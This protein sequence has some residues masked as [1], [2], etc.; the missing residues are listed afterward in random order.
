MRSA[1]SAIKRTMQIKGVLSTRSSVMENLWI[2]RQASRRFL[3]PFRLGVTRRR[4]THERVDR[5]LEQI[6]M[7]AL[8][9]R[10]AGDVVLWR[11]RHARNRNGADIPDPQLAVARRT[12][13]R[14]EPRGNR[15]GRCQDPRTRAQGRH[16]DYRARH[17]RRVRPCRPDITVLAQGAILCNREPKGNFRQPSAFARPISGG[18]KTRITWRRPPLLSLNNVHVHIGKLHILQGVN[19]EKHQARL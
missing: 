14:N 8:A 1:A 17:G 18:L 4:A 15:A 5:T 6:G 12:H 2:T 11:C 16:R 3:H 10:I 19:L 13:L 7:T 9:H